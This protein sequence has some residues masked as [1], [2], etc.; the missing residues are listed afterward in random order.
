MTFIL[1]HDKTIIKTPYQT[2]ILVPARDI[3]SKRLERLR[4]AIRQGKM[5]SMTEVVSYC[6]LKPGKRGQML[7]IM[8][9]NT[10]GERHGV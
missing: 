6:N 2:F 1:Y 3:Y 8:L 7:G 9:V 4:E 5:R 10:L